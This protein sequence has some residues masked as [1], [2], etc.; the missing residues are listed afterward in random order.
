MHNSDNNDMMIGT[1]TRIELK[2]FGDI[3]SWRLR[4]SNITFRRN[5]AG[6]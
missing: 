4:N 5:H 3:V 6:R 2:K 1:V